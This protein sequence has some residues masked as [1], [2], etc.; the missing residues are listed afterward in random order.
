MSPEPV[1]SISDDE[2]AADAAYWNQ[3]EE[4]LFATPGFRTCRSARMTYAILRASF[5]RLYVHHRM[6]AAA[7]NAFQQAMRLAPQACQAHHDY[8]YYMLIPRGQIDQAIGI[9]ER[10]VE[11]YP[12][13]REYQE[14][15]DR[16]KAERP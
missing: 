14:P 4:T 3:M 12:G 13:A 16:L 15:L 6:E 7:E 2:A 5:A 10:L 1:E 11:T 8:A 9:L